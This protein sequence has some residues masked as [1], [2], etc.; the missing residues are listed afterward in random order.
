[1]IDAIYIHIP[2]CQNKCYYCDFL[3]YKSNAQEQKKYFEYVQ[4]EISLQKKYIYD[5]VYFGG[6]TPSIVEIKYI[7]ELL[8]ILRKKENAEITIEINPATVDY[9][10]LKKYREIGINRLSIGCQSFDN[11]ILTSLGRKHTADQSIQVYNDARKA[12]FRNISVDLI[13]AVPDQTI[14][15]LKN[16]LEIIKKLSP[17]HISIYS[18]IW[19]ENTKFWN[20]REMGKIKEVDEDIEADMYSLIIETLKSMGY[21]HY[22]ISTFAKRGYLSK[23]NLKYWENKYYIGIGQGASGYVEGLRYKNCCILEQYYR[24]LDKN[25]LPYEEREIIDNKTRIEYKHLLGLRMLEKGIEIGKEYQEKA[26]KL[27]IRGFLK[28]NEIGNVILTQKGL[29]FA[30]NVFEEFLLED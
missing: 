3:S 5:T 25:L 27:I 24:L 19:K 9:E 12:G 20:M 13:F 30:N 10:K 8:K 22:E 7:E 2:F 18:L 23:H 1:M 16:D 17:E 14:D 15:I 28:Y 4:K 26:E 11:K 29:F 6:G 21:I